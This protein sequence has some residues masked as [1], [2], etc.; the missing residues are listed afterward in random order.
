MEKRES[1]EVIYP[2]TIGDLQDEA[3]IRIG[4][5]LNDGELYIAKKCVESGISCVMDITLRAAI[6]EAV[7]KISVN[8]TLLF[9]RK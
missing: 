8:S 1:A 6:D 5:V 3:I 9:K 7:D 4:R 2:I